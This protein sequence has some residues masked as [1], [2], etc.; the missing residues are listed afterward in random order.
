[1]GEKKVP[2]SDLDQIHVPDPVAQ[3]LKAMRDKISQLEKK[4]KKQEK[5][6]KEASGKE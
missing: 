2:Q 1:M 3:E 6:Q 4:I 5:Q